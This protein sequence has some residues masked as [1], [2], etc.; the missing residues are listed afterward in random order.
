MSVR[1]SSPELESG[2]M[3][4]DEDGSTKVGVV[5]VTATEKTTAKKAKKKR[6]RNKK[7]KVEDN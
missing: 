3:A 7:G 2:D 1:Y 5:T 4:G 6:N